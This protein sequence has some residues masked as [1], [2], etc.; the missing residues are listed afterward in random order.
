MNNVLEIK[1]LTKTY[2]E[3]KLDNVS[4]GVKEGSI[5]G[6]IGRNGAGKSTTLKS[7]MNL[8]H[9]D[10]G[11]IFFFGKPFAGNEA[12]IKENVGY[13]LGEV[14]YYFRK[15]IKQII[16]VTKRFYKNWSETDYR[17]Y[18]DLFSLSEEKK[19][20][21]LSAGMKVKFNLVLA[22]SHKAKLL[23]LDEPT[24][25]LDPVSREELLDV[26]LSLKDEGVSILFSTHITSDL[27]KCADRIAYLKRGRIE[28]FGDTKDFENSYVLVKVPPEKMTDDLKKTFIGTNR[29]RDYISGLTLSANACEYTGF[30]TVKPTL[31]EVMIHL[32]KEVNAK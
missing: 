18:M 14:D 29:T 4:F 12:E 31:E 8:V 30:E 23:I 22:L 10:S 9:P 7:V 19:P 16:D 17:E 21:E 24:S 27:E 32:E 2:P 3:F 6:F 5:T 26:F 28:F 20:M 11:E 25:G 13:A 1:N 15:K